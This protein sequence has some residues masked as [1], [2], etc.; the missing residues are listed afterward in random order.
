MRVEKLFV[1]LISMIP[2]FKKFPGRWS[3][4]VFQCENNT[5]PPH[6]YSLQ[7][8]RNLCL[9]WILYPAA[10][11]FRFLSF[12]GLLSTL[13]QSALSS[14]LHQCGH[15]NRFP[16][17]LASEWVQPMKDFTRDLK[18]Y[19]EWSQSFNSVSSFSVVLLGFCCT[20]PIN[21]HSFIRWLIPLR[22]LFQ[23]LVLW[24]SLIS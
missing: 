21:S 19:K 13:L 14:P 8:R 11:F 22:Y 23:I 18:L 4:V 16:V 5:F 9:L 6:R 1:F 20:P 7:S 12:P 17:R 10:C 24:A 3:E 2:V 15:I